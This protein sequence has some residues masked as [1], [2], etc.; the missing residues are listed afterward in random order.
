MPA[1]TTVEELSALELDGLFLSN[2]PG[3]P[4]TADGPVELVRWALAQKLPVF[5][6]CFGNQILARVL[7]VAARTSCSSGI[8]ESTNQ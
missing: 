7:W 5:G 4:A 3:D 8:G 2:G 6:I 1:T